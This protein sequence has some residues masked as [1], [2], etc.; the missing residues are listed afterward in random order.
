MTTTTTTIK[1]SCSTPTTQEAM[2][3]V[4]NPTRRRS[5]SGNTGGSIDGSSSARCVCA[6][7]A[8]VRVFVHAR[9]HA[10]VHACVL[11]YKIELSHV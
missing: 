3:Y 10:C 7:R 6:C 8:C 11:V 9:V 5:K 4:S 2:D 1:H